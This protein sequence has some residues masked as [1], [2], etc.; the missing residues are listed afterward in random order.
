MVKKFYLPVMLLLI[1][2]FQMLASVC[3]FARE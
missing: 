2:M 1:L 3:V